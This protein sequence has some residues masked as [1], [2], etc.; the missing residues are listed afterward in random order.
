MRAIRA[1]PRPQTANRPA[2]R[3]RA[4]RAGAAATALTALAL[5]AAGCG[6]GS[7]SSGVAH[8]GTS[9]AASTSSA[10]SGGA[11][12]SGGAP[13]SQA[14]AYSACMR[15]HGVPD[16]P[17][18]RVSTSGGEVKVAIGVTPAITGNPHFESAQQACSKL[19]PGGGSGPSSNS[20][21]SPQEQSQ[22]LK[23]AACI[24]TH[25]IPNFPDPTFSG[26]GVHVSQKGIDLHSPQARAAEEACQSLIPGGLHGNR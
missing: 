26:G 20:Q 9:T 19:L 3:R 16:F 22:Y 5:L 6:G 12:S 2:P 4:A 18:P 11:S 8:L 23:A 14:V 10:G 21:I 1:I 17:D 24:R 15:T 13:D 7:P 25:G